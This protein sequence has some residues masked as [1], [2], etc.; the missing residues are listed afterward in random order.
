MRKQV[1]HWSLTRSALVYSDQFLDQ[2]YV[3]THSTYV[4][5]HETLLKKNIV[6]SKP[7]TFTSVFLWTV[8]LNLPHGWLLQDS[9]GLICS[10]LWRRNRCF[11][12]T[13]SGKRYSLAR[14]K[15]PP[16]HKVFHV[17]QRYNAPVEDRTRRALVTNPLDL[18]T[19][20]HTSN[21]K[22]IPPRHKNSSL[23]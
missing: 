15:S 5:T 14:P 7:K 17:S 6:I 13:L 16:R 11:T 4:N 10:I 1:E 23:R 12:K 21:P 9:K 22:K 18:L 8:N 2:H 3:G 19:T 20:Q